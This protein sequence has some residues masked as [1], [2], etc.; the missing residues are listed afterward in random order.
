MIVELK[1]DR[2]STDLKRE[3]IKT[4]KESLHDIFEDAL[5]EIFWTENHLVKALPQ[6]AKATY[7][8]LLQ[9]VFEGHLEKTQRQL[10]RLENCFELFALKPIGKKC[11]AVDGL[12]REAQEVIQHFETGHARDVALIAGVQK[13]QHY[14]ISV[15][16]TL[17]TLVTVL[18]NASCT[19]S[20]EVSKK[21][22]IETDVKLTELAERIS[23][24]AVDMEEEEVD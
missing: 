4:S 21:E 8:E 2:S 6:I 7:N 18:G 12:V 9:E 15:Y 16:G 23:K 3:I 22:E 11:Y 20:M 24:L 5:K 1:V 13:I 14:A 10:I 17:Q 19:R